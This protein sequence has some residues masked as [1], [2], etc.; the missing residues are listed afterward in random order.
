MA[1][2]NY[3]KQAESFLRKTNTE[4]TAT[5]LKN[6]TYFD[7]DKDKRDIYEITLK[8]GERVYKFK[9]GQSIYASGEYI[10][11]AP[12]GKLLCTKA[13]AKRHH[14]TEKH[15]NK[16]FAVPT[17]YDVLS[18]LQK[19]DVGTFEDFCSGY[20]YSTDSRKAEATYK[21][22]VDEYD[23]LKMLYNE[24]EMQELQEIN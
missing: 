6:G 18:S 17:A 19:Y 14:W 8:R 12:E 9:F 3:E 5:Y 10:V 16:N 20:G 21:A 1:N 4:F 24:A 11:Y 23:N 22:V 15:K 2:D 13:E 7:D